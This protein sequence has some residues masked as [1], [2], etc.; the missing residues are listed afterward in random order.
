MTQQ[1][2]NSAKLALTF[3]DEFKT[4]VSSPDGSAGWMTSFPYGGDAARTLSGNHEAEYYSDKSVGENPFSVSK[5][6]LTI[7]ASPA[8]PGSNPDGLPYDSGLMTTYKSFAQTYGIFEVRAELPAGQGLWP[9]F[10]L[11]PADNVYSSELDVFEQLGSDP[12]TIYSTT[13]GST[14]GQWSS[15]FQTLH[16]ADTSTSFHNYAVDWEP[17]T[18]TFYMDGHKIASAP[19]PASMNQPMYMLLNLAVGGPGSWPGAASGS[20]IPA[21]MKIKWV[22]AFATANT[23][24]ISGTAALLPTSGLS[25]ADVLSGQTASAQDWS[26][27]QL[28]SKPGTAGGTTHASAATAHGLVA[29]PVSVSIGHGLLHAVHH[30]F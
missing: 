18:T 27:A 17:K 9:A 30:S 3:D 23:R 28:S 19:T 13:H 15:D 26:L 4:F 1:A 29:D 2:T 10:W 22:R 25:M 11:L 7:T 24:D 12:S 14:N 21:D 5:G 6:V 20:A 8:A 16:V